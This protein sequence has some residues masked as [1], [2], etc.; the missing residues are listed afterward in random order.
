[1]EDM[2]EEMEEDMEEDTEEDTGD[3]L[4]TPLDPLAANDFFLHLYS[5]GLGLLTLL[6]NKIF[7]QQ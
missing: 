1:M 6:R 2:E 7:T 5:S 3:N 4:N